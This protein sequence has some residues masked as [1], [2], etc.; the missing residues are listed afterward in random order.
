MF[1]CIYIY[2][3]NKF[4]Y[5]FF[6]LFVFKANII[7]IIIIKINTIKFIRTISSSPTL[8]NALSLNNIIMLDLDK[9]L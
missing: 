8:K 5:V 6:Y 4:T 9:I 2:I 3:Y 7:I 1:A